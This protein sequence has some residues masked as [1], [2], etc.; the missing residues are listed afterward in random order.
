MAALVPAQPVLVAHDAA[1]IASDSLCI[2]ARRGADSCG[3]LRA[4]HRA[5]PEP[6]PDSVLLPILLRRLRLAGKHSKAGGTRKTALVAG[7]RADDGWDVLLG[8]ARFE[9]SR[10]VSRSRVRAG[11]CLEG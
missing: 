5:R 8:D 4:I 6:L 1:A 3:G 9:P 11:Q 2:A 10:G 7:V